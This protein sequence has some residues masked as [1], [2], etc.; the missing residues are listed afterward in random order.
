[1]N[2]HIVPPEKWDADMAAR[3]EAK[4][5]N[6]WKTEKVMTKYLPYSQEHLWWNM[7]PGLCV[8]AWDTRITSTQYGLP[9][10][11]VLSSL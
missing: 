8:E 7:I 10:R 9:L 11:F 2:V 5:K 1:M 3:L 6:F 4:T